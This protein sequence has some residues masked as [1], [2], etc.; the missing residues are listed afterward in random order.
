M[1]ALVDPL[2]LLL[3]ILII[4]ASISDDSTKVGRTLKHS[5]AITLAVL[6]FLSTGV[7]TSIFDSILSVQTTQPQDWAPDYIFVLGGGYEVGNT[8]AEDFLGTESARR[9]NAASSIWRK[10][11][12]SIVVFAGQDPGTKDLRPPTR[13]GELAGERAMS[14]GLDKSRIIIESKSSNTR[15]H[16]I[17]AKSL[18]GLKPDTP[19]A[20]VTS[21][22][23]LR[24]SLREFHRYF[25]N[26]ASFGTGDIQDEFSWLD[27]VPLTAHLDDNSTRLKEF[28]GLIIYSLSS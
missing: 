17:Q 1:R 10:Y 27:F 22:F 20:I 26:V 23:H 28:A 3:A 19:I 5:G 6:I 11:P 24:R 2:W 9:V 8:P 18:N 15:E 25:F 13:H 7:A 14:F 12:N 21:N 16:A 4:T